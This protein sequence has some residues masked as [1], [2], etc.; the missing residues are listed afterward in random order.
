[1]IVYILLLILFAIGLYGVLSQRNL[2]KIVISV[3]ILEMAVNLFFVAVG[4]RSADA[5]LASGSAGSRLEAGPEAAA[6]IRA[7]G[8]TGHDLAARA[9]DP[10]PQAMV[11]TSIVIGL[12][13]LVLL[14]TISLRLYQRYGTYDISEIRK[15]RG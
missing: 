6:P 15:L 14:V 9:V 8:E 4:Y 3:A 7:I 12:G 5:P 11:L 1:M 13:V 2:I 10:F